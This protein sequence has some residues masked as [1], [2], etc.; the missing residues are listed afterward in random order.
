MTTPPPLQ[1]KGPFDP[2]GNTLIEVSRGA[3]LGALTRLELFLDSPLFCSIFVVVGNYV[4]SAGACSRFHF[5]GVDWRPCQPKTTKIASF[6][7]NHLRNALFVTL[8]F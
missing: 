1:P 2:P 6:K 3:F 4:W 5:L 8:L 7:I